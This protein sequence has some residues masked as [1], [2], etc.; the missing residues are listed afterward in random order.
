M[1]YIVR[2]PEILGGMPVIAGTRIPVVKIISL[3]SDGFTIETIH[4]QYPQLKVNI[5]NRVIREVERSFAKPS[6][7]PSAAKI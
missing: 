5:L 2:N 6:S 1:K 7:L 3:L 4:E